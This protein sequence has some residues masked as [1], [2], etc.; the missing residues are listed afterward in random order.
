MTPIT[1][2]TIKINNEQKANAL[3]NLPESTSARIFWVM[4]GVSGVVMK[5]IGESVV[6]E[7]AKANIKPVNR[8]GLING[9]VIFRK[10]VKPDAPSDADASSIAGLICWRAAIPDR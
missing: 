7:C 8:A 1:I 3:P 10:V 2:R 9:N 5:M 4:I 6:I